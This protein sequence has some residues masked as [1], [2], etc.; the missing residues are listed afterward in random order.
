MKNTY[1]NFRKVALAEGISFLFLL[2]V[3]MPLKYFAGLPKAVTITG[4]LH[5]ILF[6]AFA[7]LAWELKTRHNKDFRWL[8]KA[9]LASI[10]PFG[11]F[12]QDREWKK[13][14]AALSA[15]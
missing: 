2:L 4:S 9:G 7:A 10:L 14:E 6:V 5:G 11:T 15:A 13:E 12:V 1:P 3:A 8:L